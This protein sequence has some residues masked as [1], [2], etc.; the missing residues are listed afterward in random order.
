MCSK[1]YSIPSMV[2]N[3]LPKAFVRFIVQ[4]RIDLYLETLDHCSF[5]ASLDFSVLFPIPWCIEDT[6]LGLTHR[7]QTLVDV[8]KG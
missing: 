6:A 5:F 3:I 1:A 7:C 2:K 8:E 4:E